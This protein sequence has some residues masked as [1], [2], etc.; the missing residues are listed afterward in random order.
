MGPVLAL[1]A[2]TVAT[3]VHGGAIEPPSPPSPPSYGVKVERAWIRMRDGVRLAATLFVP[4]GGSSGE[5][6][7]ALLEYLPYRKDDETLDSDYP[8]HTYFAHRGYVTARVDIRGTGASEGATPTR[9]YSQQEQSDGEQVIAWLAGRPWSNGKVGMFGI[10]WGGF[11]SIQMAMRRPPALKAIIAVCATEELYKEDIHYIDG[12]MHVDEFE[13]QM[14][15]DQSMSR[16]P[17]FPVDERTLA[18]RFDNPPWS[19][20]YMEHQRDGAFW[21]EPVRPLPSI[22]IPVFMIGGM[23]DGYRDSIPR[24]LQTLNVPMKAIIGPWNHTYPDDAV[25]GPSIEWRRQAVRWWDYWLKGRDT[26]I[27]REPQIAVYMQHWHKPDVN[28]ALIPG[29]WRWE[30]RWPPPEAQPKTFYLARAGSLHNAPPPVAVDR[31]RYV[32]STGVEAG[33]WWGDLTADQRGADAYSLVYDSAPLTQPMAILGKPDVIM[34]VSASAPLADWFVRLCDVAPDGTDTQVTGGGINGAQRDSSTD[35]RY[36]QPGK[37]YT[38]NLPLHLTSWVFAAGHRIRIAVSNSWWPTIWST[39]YAMTTSL[40]EG[41]DNASRVVLP[42]VPARAQAGPDFGLPQPSDQ[43]AGVRSQGS[44]W[45]GQYVV[46]RDESRHATRVEWR[47]W[48]ANRYPWGT[49]VHHERLIYDVADAHPQENVVR[50]DADTTWRVGRRTLVYQGHLR[51]RSDK[52]NFYYS[53]ERDLLEN[54]RL[55]RR[56]IWRKTILRDHQ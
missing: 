56:K 25:P 27:M 39:P 37:T 23:L 41:G 51:M 33:F 16:S 6:F 44:V 28:L 30:S 29:Q 42:T 50:G 5:K 18:A 47:G 24:M 49:R 22:R 34:N 13:V 35:P 31:L 4:T 8:L 52:A 12:M 45:P 32:P 3:L 21:R 48:D 14:D 38:L 46:I 40:Y 36:L 11:N 20:L 1:A 54:G 26:G 15:L 55:I 10:S 2:V 9:E 43:L 7:P 19:L 53:Y 17:D